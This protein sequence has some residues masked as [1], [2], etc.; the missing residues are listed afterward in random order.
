VTVF[1]CGDVMTGRG[2][3]QILPH[4]SPPQ[5]DEEFVRDARQ[6]VTLAEAVNGSVDRPVAWPYIWGD[7]LRELDRVRPDVRIINLE[8]AVTA[9]DRPWPK[10]INYRM[11]PANAPCLTAARVDCCVL[12]NNHVLDWGS[13]GLEDTLAALDTAGIRRAGAG[14]NLDEA[15]APAVLGVPGA[16][17]V[18][19]FAGGFANSGID[20]EW[21]ATGQRPGVNLLPDYSEESVRAVG[22]GVRRVKHAGDLVVASFHWGGNWGYD[23]P[24][25]QRDFARALID[26][27]GVDLVHGHSSHHVK[28]IEVY[29]GRLILYGCGDFLTDYEGIEGHETY[30]DDL[31]L[32]YFPALDPSTGRVLRCEMTPTRLRRL[33]VTRAEPE[34]ARWLAD[35]LNREGRSL[36]TRV[37]LGDD[38]RLTLH[39][40]E[41]ASGARDPGDPGGDAP[42]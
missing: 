10:G 13:A 7:A 24:A 28:G 23:I 15:R 20:R 14:R 22:E 40:R 12:A 19:V 25:A 30:R 2:I 37:T 41:S 3:D 33:R 9:S 6:Y 34:D 5:L 4:P 16:G 27:A 1:L 18:L 26:D 38:N 42:A 21:G 8:T 39:W 35:V 36:G 29:R 31:G 32:M 11:A 17:R